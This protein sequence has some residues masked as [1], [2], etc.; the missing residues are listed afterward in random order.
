MVCVDPSNNVTFWTKHYLSETSSCEESQDLVH[1]VKERLLESTTEFVVGFLTP[2][3]DFETKSERELTHFSENT[4]LFLTKLHY[5]NWK[6]LEEK[7][8]KQLGRKAGKVPVKII[9][10]AFGDSEKR[11]GHVFKVVVVDGKIFGTYV[12]VNF[13]GSEKKTL[14]ERKPDCGWSSKEGKIYCCTLNARLM[15]RMGLELADLNN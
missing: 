5:G 11:T 4:A 13:D 1:M 8:R 7:I 10:G 3:C 9:T 14:C 15:K 12:G 2:S 6:K